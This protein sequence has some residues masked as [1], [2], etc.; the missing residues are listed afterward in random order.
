M[1][2]CGELSQTKSSERERGPTV[3]VNEG[4]CL[5]LSPY[6]VDYLQH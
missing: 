4:D 6:V 5:V 3:E 1:G 2:S